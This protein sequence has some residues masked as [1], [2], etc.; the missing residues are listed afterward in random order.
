MR[1]AHR[2]RC[3]SCGSCCSCAGRCGPGCRRRVGSGL[4]CWLGPLQVQVHLPAECNLPISGW[5]RKDAPGA[6][7]MVERGGNRRVPQCTVVLAAAAVRWG[8]AFGGH[9]LPTQARGRPW[10]QGGGA[11]TS[12][13]CT[14]CKAGGHCAPLPAIRAAPA[15]A[16]GQLKRLAPA[17][18]GP[19]PPPHRGTTQHG[20]LLPVQPSHGSITAGKP[21]YCS[22]GV[23]RRKGDRAEQSTA[24]VRRA[25]RQN[26][27]SGCGQSRMGEGIQSK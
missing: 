19:S 3:H 21:R 9:P 12:T 2:C 6:T 7:M 11:A 1:R 17:P 14:R 23:E 18:P 27:V 5:S 16:L 8:R 4:P 25:Q 26:A 13:E 15:A 22:A 20:T 24:G 10:Q